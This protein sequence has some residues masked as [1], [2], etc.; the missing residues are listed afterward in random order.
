ML[1][2]SNKKFRISLKEQSSI[3]S[4]STTFIDINELK[5][6]INHLS[7]ENVYQVTFKYLSYFWEGENFHSDPI[8]TENISQ[9]LFDWVVD[10]VEGTH[11][12]IEIYKRK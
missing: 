7:L 2:A 9:S 3:G 12:F 5:E 10:N 4:Y 11:R 1:I 6:L 8:K